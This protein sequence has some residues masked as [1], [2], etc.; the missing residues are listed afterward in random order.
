MQVGKE[1]KMNMPVEDA[2][3]KSIETVMD[4][5]ANEVNMNKTYVLLRTYAPVH[6]RFA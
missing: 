1:V 2:F 6:F 4:W 3:K 5:I